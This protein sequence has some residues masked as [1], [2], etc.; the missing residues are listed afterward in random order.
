MHFTLH[1]VK[2]S[3]LHD[4]YPTLF[5]L[6][7]FGDMNVADPRDIA[8]MK[9]DAIA[10]R[11]SRRD[12]VDLYMVAHEYGLHELFECFAR[13]YASVPYSRLHLLKA[14]TYFRDAEQDPPPDMFISL[15]WSAVAGS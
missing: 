10:S 1:G 7:R 9:I 6:R 12:F 5:P 3:L 2:V 14:L 8:C 11:G 13:K 4:P 15:D